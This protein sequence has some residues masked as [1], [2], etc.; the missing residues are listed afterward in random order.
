MLKI[1]LVRTWYLN[2][3]KYFQ[4]TTRNYFNRGEKAARSGE[5]ERDSDLRDLRPHHI[6]RRI[7]H[8]LLVFHPRVFQTAQNFPLHSRASLASPLPRRD[9]RAADAGAAVDQ[10]APGQGGADAAERGAAAPLVVQVPGDEQ[11]AEQDVDEVRNQ[12]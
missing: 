1:S 7:H 3:D 6:L 2:S 12:R 5:K 9:P 10:A 4:K 11:P 8:H